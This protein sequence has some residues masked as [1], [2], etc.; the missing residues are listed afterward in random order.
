MESCGIRFIDT[1]SGVAYRCAGLKHHSGHH[2]ATAGNA[3]LSDAPT[4]W[5]VERIENLIS[6]VR[7]RPGQEIDPVAEAAEIRRYLTPET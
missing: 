4:D 5:L 3:R 7:N 6:D 1:A 2:G